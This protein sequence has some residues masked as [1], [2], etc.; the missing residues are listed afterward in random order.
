MRS[1]GATY[2]GVA[3]DGANVTFT[4]SSDGTIVDSYKVSDVVV[5]NACTFLAEGDSGVWPGAPIVNSTFEYTLADAV[6]FG[7]AFPGPQLVAF[8]LY[9]A[10]T[11]G[12]PAC[13]TGT[14]SWTA[15]TT[16][17]PPPS[18]SGNGNGSGN[19]KGTGSGSGG[20]AHRFASRVALR[21]LSPK[22]DGG[23]I[24][25]ASSACRANRKVILWRGRR[26]IASTRSK[27]GGR[28]SFARSATV[29]HHSIRA[30]VAARTV[31]AG[32]CA[33]G[34]STFIAG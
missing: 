16:A 33:A 2:N 3:A 17:T 20:G 4:V 26:R 28:F 14:V 12:R 32:I 24:I 23:R 34:S 13:D 11:N 18:G 1:P 29:R 19:G 8:R 7:G 25:S 9:D 22:L 21:R 15:T 10:A 27:A 31:P 30:S 6:L 5:A